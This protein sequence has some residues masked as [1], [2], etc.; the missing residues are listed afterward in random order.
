MN[1]NSLTHYGVKGMKWGVRK[2]IEKGKEKR[3][4]KKISR[5]NSRNLKARNRIEKSGGSLAR[6]NV[7]TV[8]AGVANHV[9]L[10]IGSGTIAGLTGGSKSSIAGYASS[11]AS[12]LQLLNAAN[13][14]L[15]VYDNVKNKK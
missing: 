4:A 12:L 3:A 6:A 5:K 1:D 2:R 11:A 8:G 15:K 10:N 9:L 7:G 13:T 14:G